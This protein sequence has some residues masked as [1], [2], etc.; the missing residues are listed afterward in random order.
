MQ[1]LQDLSTKKLA[2]YHMALKELSGN[3]HYV[4]SQYL[5]LFAH[6]SGRT[7]NV[8][9]YYSVITYMYV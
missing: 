9:I 2:V 4:V 7:V 8:C 6:D 3:L 1:A 5:Y